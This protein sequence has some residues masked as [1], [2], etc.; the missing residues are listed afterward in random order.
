MEEI[1]EASKAEGMNNLSVHVFAYEYSI[2]NYAQTRNNYQPTPDDYEHRIYKI[3]HSTYK[4]EKER[5]VN[6]F[7]NEDSEGN[8]HF[9]LITN[10]SRL[11]SR[12]NGDNMKYYCCRCLSY[13]YNQ[14]KL[15]RHFENCENTPPIEH[16][17]SR[18]NIEK[19]K[20]TKNIGKHVPSAYCLS[21]T[22]FDRKYLGN[23]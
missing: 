3:R 20:W 17:L 6:L 11:L 16:R 19:D 15:D 9:S 8:G 12:S 14:E 7:Y 2:S 18:K 1:T 5:T 23:M 13:Y 10:L 22:F 21:F 4:C